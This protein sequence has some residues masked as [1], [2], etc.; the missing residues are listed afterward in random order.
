MGR[1]P[2]PSASA[3]RRPCALVGLVV[4]LGSCGVACGPAQKEP[5]SEPVV[6]IGQDEVQAPAA[7]EG[8][9][10]TPQRVDAGP[11]SDLDRLR[12]RFPELQD[13]Q[14]GSPALPALLAWVQ[15]KERIELWLVTDKY[16]CAQVFATRNTDERLDIDIVDAE[17]T[18]AGRRYRDI[19]EGDAGHLLTYGSGGRSERQE[20]DGSWKPEPTMWGASGGAVAG[21]LS[22]VDAER[23]RYDGRPQFLTV[24][25][26]KVSLPCASGGE[27]PCRDCKRI[28]VQTSPMTGLHGIIAIRNPPLPKATCHDECPPEQS[29]LRSEVE[30]MVRRLREPWLA[31]EPSAVG[32]Y[33]SPAEC[34]AALVAGR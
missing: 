10:A 19:V 27:R 13:L 21:A 28:Q 4:T 24:V 2:G 6:P 16:R 3:G 29:E 20:P 15:P 9:A 18:V 31:E 26:P 34:Q 25:C 12:A 22:Q 30:A 1:A 5:V 11:E 32:L 14:S 17:R 23:A 8:D 33:R 7:D